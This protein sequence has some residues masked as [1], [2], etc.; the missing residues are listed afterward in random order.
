ME[1]QHEHQWI[2]Q[3]SSHHLGVHH[4]LKLTPTFK[5]SQ[6]KLRGG[7]DESERRS[8]G[9]GCFSGCCFTAYGYGTTQQAHENVYMDQQWVPATVR[10]PVGFGASPA[11][12][13]LPNHD[14]QTQIV[15]KGVWEEV[16]SQGVVPLPMW[17]C[18]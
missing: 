13:D 14:T 18:S 15:M 7:H 17:V 5:K 11:A 12:S 1:K 16:V 6:S 2:H 4:D 9:G 10:K 8:W 3:L